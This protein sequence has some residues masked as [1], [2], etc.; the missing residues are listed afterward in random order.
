MPQRWSNLKPYLRLV[1]L[2]ATLVFLGKT[3]QEHA[4]EITAIR[5]DG[6][7]W[8]SL[9]IALGLTLLAH[10]W[11]GWVWGWVLQE[12]EQSVDGIWAIQ[13]YLKTNIAKYLPS[14]LLHLYGRTMAATAAGVTLG[15][16][17]L[18]VLLEP[19]LLI[20][21]ALITAL[22]CTTWQAWGGQLLS[23]A[24]VLIA[25]HPWV[26]N[27]AIQYLSRFKGQRRNSPRPELETL[28]IKRYPL[29][30][31]LGE[32]GF[33]GLRS[34]GFVLTVAALTPVS[35]QAVPLLVG[36]FSIGWLLGFITPGAP[37]GLGVFEVTV[38]ALLESSPA[39]QNLSAGLALSAIALYRLLSTLAEALGAGL[40]WLDGL[41]TTPLSKG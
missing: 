14:N 41:H 5:I 29:R 36:A 32:L 35:P 24:A 28:R 25:L 40:A 10:I 19:L 21:A 26:L 17:T 16:A 22:V 1:I 34:S 39:S 31:L 8:A 33:L 11:T 13:T 30:P 9:A 7:G 3:L 38:L 20:A 4:Q 23:L 27:Q 18:S 6:P 2:I 37:G 15:A 12:L